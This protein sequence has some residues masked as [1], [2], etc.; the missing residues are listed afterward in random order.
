MKNKFLFIV[1]AFACAFY[2]A[3]KMTG[4]PALAIIAVLC[5][6]VYG[7]YT[8]IYDYTH[9]TFPWR[10]TEAAKKEEARKR[11]DKAMAKEQKIKAKQDRRVAYMER[12]TGTGKGSSEDKEK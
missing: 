9:N 4:K 2:L 12:M 6:V 10:K 3:Y 8:V 5:I 1:L 7:I 11:V